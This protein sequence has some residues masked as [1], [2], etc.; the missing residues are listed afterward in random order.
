MYLSAP[1]GSATAGASA[2]AIMTFGAAPAT[3]NGLT[4]LIGVPLICVRAPLQ[5]D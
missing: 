2:A 4:N 1:R 3:W 5:A